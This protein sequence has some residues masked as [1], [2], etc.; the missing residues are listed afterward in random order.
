MA[1]EKASVD[2]LELRLLEVGGLLFPSL[3]VRSSGGLTLSFPSGVRP[4][5]EAVNHI[6]EKTCRSDCTCASE[7]HGEKNVVR[8]ASGAGLESGEVRA[9]RWR[10]RRPAGDSLRI[11]LEVIYTV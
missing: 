7:R 10:R 8:M 9:Y 1:A 6:S 4:G 11:T 2:P 5:L 3:I